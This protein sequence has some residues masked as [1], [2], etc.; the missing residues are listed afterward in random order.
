MTCSYNMK[1]EACPVY[2][3]KYACPHFM[4]IKTYIP[5]SLRI[6][7]RKPEDDIEIP[8]PEIKN[9]AGRPGITDEAVLE[10]IKQGCTTSVELSEAFQCNRNSVTLHCR[11]L[12]AAGKIRRVK[13][14]PGFHSNAAV[15]EVVR[16]DNTNT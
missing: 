16:N 6:K 14:K 8:L 3:D 9:K 11:R 12:I 1:C 4:G 2:D 7:P 5:P 15:Y 10:R 13:G